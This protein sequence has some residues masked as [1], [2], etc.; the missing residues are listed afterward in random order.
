MVSIVIV[1]YAFAS[2]KVIV[3]SKKVIVRYAF[4][5]KKVIVASKKVIVRYAF[6][7][8]STSLIP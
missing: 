3:A 6:Q 5:S 2:K 4:A 7:K 1:R 8:N